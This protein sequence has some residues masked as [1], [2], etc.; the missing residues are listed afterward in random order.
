MTRSWPDKVVDND[1]IHAIPYSYFMIPWGENVFS[2]DHAVDIIF[3]IGM[4]LLWSINVF[5]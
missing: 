5:V 3:D 4:A 1:W 2:A